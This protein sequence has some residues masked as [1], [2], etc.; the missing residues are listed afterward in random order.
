[1]GFEE[2]KIFLGQPIDG[3]SLALFRALF[4]LLMCGSIFHKRNFLISY[5]T[6]FDFY[7]KY[8][9]LEFIKP[10]GTWGMRVVIY[11]LIVSLGCF[12]AGLFY[13]VSVLVALILYTYI[14]LLDKA[15]YNNHYYLIILFLF[16]FNFV[17]ASH[18]FALDNLIFIKDEPVTQIPYWN[19]LIFQLQLL[20]VYTYGGL[21]KITY[22]WLMRGEPMTV[23]FKAF[24]PKTN[25]DWKISRYC[26]SDS[27]IAKVSMFF[28]MKYSGL[29]FS[30]F[31]MI[32]DLLII[33]F[34]LIPAT[35][36]YAL[37]LFIFFHLF[38]LWFFM[39]GIFPYMNFA[40]IVLF[41]SPE[42]SRKLIQMFQGGL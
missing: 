22:D 4:G 1:M 36:P 31:G 14:F 24:I 21:N 13:H 26:W 30:W 2:L 17:D 8:P 7:F 3:S 15:M 28:K 23:L 9:F 35:L 10:L 5:Y 40:V 27:M 34:M 19:V 16:F 32:F 12:S 20:I 6:S 11:G 42:F 41:L 18:V 25:W 37:P 33:S 38:N 29:I 39:I